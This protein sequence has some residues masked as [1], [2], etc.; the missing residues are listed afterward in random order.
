M[1]PLLGEEAMAQDRN[2]LEPF[3]FQPKEITMAKR[4]K[5]G[6]VKASHLKKGRGRKRGRK[7]GGKKSA[8]K[9]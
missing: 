3:L 9:A 2:G 7:R 5:I 4:H 8:I 1:P 6:M